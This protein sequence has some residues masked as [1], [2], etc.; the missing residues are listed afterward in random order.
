MREC[1]LGPPRHPLLPSGRCRPAR[2][3]IPQNF[4]RRGT[5]A[6]SGRTEPLLA[7]WSANLRTLPG[8]QG[9]PAAEVS[10]CDTH[11]QTR[12][13]AA[14][15][16]GTL[17]PYTSSRQRGTEPCSYPSSPAWSTGVSTPPSSA[18]LNESEARSGAGPPCQSQRPEIRHR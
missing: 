5:W 14:Y 18:G 17:L 13:R 11:T 6:C 3:V 10:Q 15:G 8:T 1:A 16:K 2:R 4:Q 7:C 12:T 9:V